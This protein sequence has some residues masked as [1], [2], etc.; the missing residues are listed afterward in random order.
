MSDANISK[1]AATVIGALL[2]G[3]GIVTAGFLLKPATIADQDKRTVFVNSQVQRDAKADNAYYNFA[4]VELGSNA[5]ELTKKIDANKQ[6]VDNFLKENGIPEADVQ[7]SLTV[8]NL[9]AESGLQSL[10][11]SPQLKLQQNVVVSTGEVDKMTALVQ[12]MNDLS[13]AGVK[14]V[15]ADQGYMMI[16]YQLLNYDKLKPELIAAAI[17]QSRQDADQVAK[18]L[19]K[20]ID[21]LYTFMPQ[22]YQVFDKGTKSM[23]G[24]SLYKSVEFDSGMEY[25][26]KN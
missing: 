26:L 23:D 17:Q 18:A 22:G 24:T 5:D 20:E 19:G 15:Q 2:I 12:K 21:S 1:P 6:V 9:A 8:H 16:N 13:K 3:L 25:S 4:F 11:D 14:I 10:P 7:Y